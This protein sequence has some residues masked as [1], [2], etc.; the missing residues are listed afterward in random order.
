MKA[1]DYEA[2]SGK[3]TFISLPALAESKSS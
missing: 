1:I 2:I 3:L